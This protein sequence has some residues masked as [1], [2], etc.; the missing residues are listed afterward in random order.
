MEIK[1]VFEWG[2]SMQNRNIIIIIY[3]RAASKR[4][5]FRTDKLNRVGIVT[6][7]NCTVHRMVNR[8]I[9]RRPHVRTSPRN[10]SV[11]MQEKKIIY[12]NLVH[13]IHV[14]ECRKMNDMV[15]KIV[16]RP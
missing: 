2:P 3:M 1:I 13:E 11:E 9:G 12:N 5:T 4:L 8:R 6:M 10:H 14:K 7:P 15:L 16:G